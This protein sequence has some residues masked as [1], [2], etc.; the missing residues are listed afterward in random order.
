MTETIAHR[1]ASSRRGLWWSEDPS[2][3]NVR[4]VGFWFCCKA[5]EVKRILFT[6]EAANPAV[7]PGEPSITGVEWWHHGSTV[8]SPQ[9]PE[10][11]LLFSGGSDRPVPPQPLRIWCYLKKHTSQR[12]KCF[13]IKAFLKED[14]PVC[15]R[16][17]LQEFSLKTP[18]QSWSIKI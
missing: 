14:F 13:T 2:P 15:W 4:K 5:T 11:A 3:A 8:L 10:L 7:Q 1:T 16:D 12:S 17:V 18:N 6:V 9:C